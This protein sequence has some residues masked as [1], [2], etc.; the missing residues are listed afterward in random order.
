MQHL[1]PESLTSCTGFPWWL[2][3]VVW[4][5][6][7]QRIMALSFLWSLCKSRAVGVQVSLP[8]KRAERMQALNT[9]PRVKGDTCL[10]VN[11][12][13][14]FLNFPQAVEHLV[15]ITRAH[16]LPAH[17]MS[18]RQQN[19][20]FEPTHWTEELGDGLLYNNFSYLF[21]PF[22]SMKGVLELS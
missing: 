20:I 17:N 3:H 22:R 19:Q 21:V 4:Q 8:C 1:P 10:E 15:A 13:S 18:P 6:L 12:G 9:F 5:Q 2:Y 16:P 14:I 7:V 11:I